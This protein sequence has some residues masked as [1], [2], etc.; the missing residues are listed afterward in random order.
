VIADDP[1]LHH[2]FD[3][4]RWDSDSEAPD[5]HCQPGEAGAVS[6]EVAELRAQLEAMRQQM[7]DLVLNQPV[8]YVNCLLAMA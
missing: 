1:F 4:E 7:A 6:R 8:K 5:A 2:D 3:G